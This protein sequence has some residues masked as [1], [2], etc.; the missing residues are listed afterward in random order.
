V[1]RGNGGRVARMPGLKALRIGL[2]QHALLPA[3]WGGQ[4]A[5]AG[6]L[7]RRLVGPIRLTGALE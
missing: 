6:A 2:A 7:M 4:T 5:A 1:D 3:H